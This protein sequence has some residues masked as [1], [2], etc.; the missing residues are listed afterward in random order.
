VIGIYRLSVMGL[1]TTSLT[2]PSPLDTPRS[3]ATFYIFHVLPE[4]LAS[5]ILFGYNIRETFGTGLL[6]DWRISDETEKQ[7]VQRLARE[8]KQ[9]AAKRRKRTEKKMQLIDSEEGSK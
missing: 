9:E 7:R 2:S 1:K 4:W 8:A 5:L 6:G 3:K